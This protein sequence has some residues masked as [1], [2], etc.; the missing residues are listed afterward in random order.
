MK[1]LNKSVYKTSP[2]PP[3]NGVTASYLQL[4]SESPFSDFFSF[5][6][7]QFPHIPAEILKQRLEKGD[8]VDQQ[9]CPFTLDS[10]YP[11]GQRI[12][13]FREVP[14]EARVPFDEQIIYQDSKLLVV[15]KPHFLSMTPGG[16]HLQETL[17]IRLRVRL[18]QIDITPIHRLDRETA[19]VVIFCTDA[20]SRGAYQTLF[21]RR[22][23]QK[24]YE[25]VAPYRSDLSLPRVHKSR[26]QERDS[27]LTMKEVRGE[28]NSET[29]ISVLKREGSRALYQLEPH[30]GRKHQLRVHLAS[31]GIP[32]ENDN[33]YPELLPDKGDDFSQPLQLLARS[34][35]FVDPFNGELR[36][37]HSQQTLAF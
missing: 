1:Q 34:I 25:A 29:R 16:R 15:D 37:F 32:I 22:E 30:T 20:Q 28:P 36:E 14:S 13:Y 2:L 35:R 33:W 4:P 18:N 26:M 12:W 9:G 10:D 6:V 8:I 24:V 7:H 11:A 21:Q 17:L 5:L 27:F 23:V 31:L 3:R 19:G